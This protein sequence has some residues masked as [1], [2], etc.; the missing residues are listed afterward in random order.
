MLI[1]KIKSDKDKMQ[2]CMLSVN[3]HWSFQNKNSQ[4]YFHKTEN[5]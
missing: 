5:V 1:M 3:Q 4:Q 2:Y